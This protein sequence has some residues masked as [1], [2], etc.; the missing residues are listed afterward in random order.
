MSLYLSGFQLESEIGTISA[1]GTKPAKILFLFVTERF[2][3]GVF[4]TLLGVIASLI[5][6][7]A[8]SAAHIEFDFGRQQ[9]LL[10]SPTIGT[11]D[12]IS[13]AGIVIVIA[14]PA[15]LQP[16]WKAAGMDPIAA[17]RHV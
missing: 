15:N 16:A 12:V 11:G 8:I 4:G 14:V 1:L 6:I 3:L 10:L 13:T 2:L 5:S 7:V 9:G 17:L